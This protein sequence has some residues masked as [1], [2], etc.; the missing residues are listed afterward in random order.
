MP[1]FSLI[2]DFYGTT[3]PRCKTYDFFLVCLDDGFIHA[4]SIIFSMPILI[5][6]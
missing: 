5:T 2:S 6:E 4:L 1:Y 3:M